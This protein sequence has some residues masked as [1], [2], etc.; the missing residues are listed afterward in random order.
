MRE[1]CPLRFDWIRSSLMEQ[2]SPPLLYGDVIEIQYLLSLVMGFRHETAPTHPTLP[3][4]HILSPQKRAQSKQFLYKSIINEDVSSTFPVLFEQKIGSV[5]DF[6]VSLKLREGTKPLGSLEAKGIIRKSDTSDWGK[7]GESSCPLVLIPKADSAVCLCVDY[8]VG[9]NKTLINSLYQIKKTELLLNNIRNS[10]YVCRYKVDDTNNN[11]SPRNVQN[12]QHQQ[13][14][15]VS[16]TKFSEMFDDVVVHSSTM[17]EC[18][19]NLYVCLKQLHKFDTSTKKSVL[20][21]KNA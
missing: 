7:V 4:L 12:E 16:S 10:K 1:Y 5:P 6:K 21:F 15:T 3:I 11:N 14:S 8:K 20:S 18:R 19:S 13:N 17:R 2:I 9:V